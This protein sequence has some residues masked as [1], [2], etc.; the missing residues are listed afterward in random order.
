MK[1][2]FTHLPLLEMTN[3]IQL[4]KEFPFQGTTFTTETDVNSLNTFSSLI[5]SPALP[6]STKYVH[7]PH[8]YNG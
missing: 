1:T 7:L 8:F 2:G 3:Q 6:T 5:C 4:T